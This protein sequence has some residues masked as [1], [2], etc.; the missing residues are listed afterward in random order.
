MPVVI[1]STRWPVRLGWVA[2]V[3]AALLSCAPRAATQIVIRI[4]AEAFLASAVYRVEVS[5]FL[6]GQEARPILG[7]AGYDLTQYGL[8]GEVVVAAA[9]PDEPRRLVVRVSAALRGAVSGSIEQRAVVPFRREQTQ[10]L[11]VFLAR[12]CLTAQCPGETCGNDGQCRPID[13]PAVGPYLQPDA[14]VDRGAPSDTPVDATAEPVTPTTDVADAAGPGDTMDAAAACPAGFADCDR[15]AGNGCEVNLLSSAH[16]GRCGG[17]CT[18]AAPYCGV[19][20]GVVGCVAA[21]TGG[22]AL[23]GSVCAD[24]QA[25][26]R[27]CGGC[28]A[29][30]AAGEACVAG[31]CVCTAPF[32]ACGGRCV[33]VRSDLSHCGACG[34]AAGNLEGC[35]NG[36]LVAVRPVEVTAGFTTCALM[37]DATVRCW[38]SNGYGQIDASRV[39]Q[40]RP[41]RLPYRDVRRVYVFI[42]EQVCVLLRDSTARCQGLGVSSLLGPGLVAFG[43]GTNNNGGI[44]PFECGVYTDGSVHCA[45]DNLA[46]QLGVGDRS[47]RRSMPIPARPMS[48]GAD[49][50]HVTAHSVCVRMLDGR[51][52]CWGRNEYGEVGNETRAA[53]FEPYELPLRGVVS[54][55]T[56]GASSHHRCARLEAGGVTC[57]GEGRLGQLGFGGTADV[58]RPGAVV[59]GTMEV[60]DFSVGG[61]TLAR[62]AARDALR[63]GVQPVFFPAKTTVPTVLMGVRD[64][65]AVGTGSQNGCVVAGAEVICWGNNEFGQ[66]G[67]GTNAPLSAFST[68]RW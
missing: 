53:V 7:D 60:V 45:G 41:V 66:L 43:H 40:L 56:Q 67:N 17:T 42:D 33:D 50:I 59:P 19:T 22:R 38:G 25:D 11:T 61:G 63:W 16:C 5:A 55:G 39:T 6:E 14:S 37:S 2:L 44:G 52:R 51:V 54:L 10:L 1:K 34:R 49:Q 3:C 68:V 30:C 23:C 27:H 32:L 65:T 18:A 20:A 62:T 8:P 36:A 47:A 31:R 57:W 21:C 46:G 12:Q 15:S 26:R 64:V 9:D 13:R 24:T 29:A 58:L 35:T 4:D 28:D 48:V